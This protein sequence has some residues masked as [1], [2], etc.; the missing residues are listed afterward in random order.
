LKEKNIQINCGLIREEKGTREPVRPEVV[1][2]A[3]ENQKK[4]NR[5]KPKRGRTNMSGTGRRGKG[6]STKRGEKDD[7]MRGP[8]STSHGWAEC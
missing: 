2:P 3:S 6:D 7:D 4:E 5:E 1:G 8:W